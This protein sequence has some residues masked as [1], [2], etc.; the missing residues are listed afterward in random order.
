[1]LVEQILPS[2][3]VFLFRILVYE[4][5]TVMLLEFCMLVIRLDCLFPCGSPQLSPVLQVA[6]IPFEID[7]PRHANLDD[8]ELPM[9]IFLG[10][11]VVFEQFDII[12]A[13]GRCKQLAKI[14]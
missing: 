11:D 3:L 8:R 2:L 4:M 10:P 14:C 9:L 1:M 6:V 5:W 7:M 12:F 13:D